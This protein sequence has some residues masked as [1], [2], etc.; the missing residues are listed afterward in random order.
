[1]RS[2]RPASQGPAVRLLGAAL[3][4]PTLLLPALLVSAAGT[5]VLHPA[6]AF[7]YEA[8]AAVARTVE[9]TVRSK[10]GPAAGAIVYLKDTKSLA[11]RSFIADSGGAFHFG[12]LSTNGDYE[13]WAEKDGH[14]SK[15]KRISSFED[16]A[17]FDFT[18][19]VE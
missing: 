10:S 12:Q 11:V 6:R 16:K 18:L 4:L 13:L 17:N 9:G 3:V 5:V 7:A 15:S 14:R 8:P 1:M 2:N 19:T